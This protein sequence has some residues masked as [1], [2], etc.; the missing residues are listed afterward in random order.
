MTMWP[1]KVVEVLLTLEPD[2]TIELP[3]GAE[4]L[5][6]RYQERFMQFSLY[7][8]VLDDKVQHVRS[9]RFLVLRDLGTLP[10]TGDERLRHLATHRAPGFCGVVYHVFEV[11]LEEP[12]GDHS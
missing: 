12:G 11:V 6:V 8:L 1:N 9:R 5:D 3:D 4:I 10:I 7:M 2:Q